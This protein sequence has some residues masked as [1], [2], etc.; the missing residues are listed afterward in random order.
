MILNIEEAE[1]FNN[2]M[3]TNDKRTDKNRGV[4]I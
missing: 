1:N 4:K 2:W 3:R